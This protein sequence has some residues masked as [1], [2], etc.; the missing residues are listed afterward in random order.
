M[1]VKHGHLSCACGVAPP[2]CTNGPLV[3]Y[4]SLAKSHTVVCMQQRVLISTCVLWAAGQADTYEI[5]PLLT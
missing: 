4:T 1:K 3:R 2:N 5:F